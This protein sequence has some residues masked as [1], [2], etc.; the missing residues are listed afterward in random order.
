MSKHLE[1]DLSQLSDRISTLGNMVIDSAT[2][3]ITMLQNFDL[4][5]A[6]EI[7][8]AEQRINDMEVEIEEECLKV[9]ALHQPVATDLR[10]LIV[11]LK[12]NNDLERMADQVVNIAERIRFI[13]DKK[14]VVA[15]LD[16]DRMGEISSTMVRLSVR[17]LVNQDA[18]LAKEVLAM[19]DE[20]DELHARS[21]QTLQKVMSEDNEIIVPA[22]SHLTISNNLERLGDLATNVAE[23]IIFM[24]EG[25]VI[26]H[27]DGDGL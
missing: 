21:Y 8:A 17:A 9:M 7:L 10:F 13:F 4:V 14:R 24:I 19:D 11:V 20:L 23:E 18:E 3:V 25:E 6:D 1:R 5:L 16:F 15:D 22:V 2:K 26:R 12:V 27:S